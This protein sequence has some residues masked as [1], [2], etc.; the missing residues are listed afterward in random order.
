MRTLLVFVLGTAC[1][2]LTV[3][4]AGMVVGSAAWFDRQKSDVHVLA[5]NDLSCSDAP[6]D[7]TPVAMGDYREVE[8]H[9]C[10][11]K[12]RYQM[13]KIGPMKHWSKSSDVSAM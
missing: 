9:G 10:A 1:A 13:I 4:C 5:A 12:V 2:Q 8:A 3:G 6:I 7:Y 11:K